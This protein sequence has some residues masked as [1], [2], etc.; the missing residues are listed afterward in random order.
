MN[1]KNGP[2]PTALKTLSDRLAR[3]P[4]NI[5]V[6]AWFFVSA[7]GT[8]DR[9]VCKPNTRCLSTKRPEKMQHEAAKYSSISSREQGVSRQPSVLSAVASTR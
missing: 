3:F 9:Y 7:Y 2:A 6:S 1:A 4:L 5:H 8:A